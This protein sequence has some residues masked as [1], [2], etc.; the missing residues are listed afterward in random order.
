MASLPPSAALAAIP[1][2]L[3]PANNLMADTDGG[4]EITGDEGGGSCEIVKGVGDK[5][6]GWGTKT[7]GGEGRGEKKRDGKSGMNVSE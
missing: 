2:N 6:K 4:V 5:N 7:K 3:L 1:A